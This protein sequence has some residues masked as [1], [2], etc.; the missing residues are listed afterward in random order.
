MVGL[1]NKDLGLEGACREV[2]SY[3]VRSLVAH[4]AS[5]LCHV[6][7]HHQSTHR[8]RVHQQKSESRVVKYEQVQEKH[9]AA[10]AA[11]S[12]ACR[13]EDGPEATDGLDQRPY[14]SS[15]SD[16]RLTHQLVLSSRGSRTYRARAL[17]SARVAAF[18]IRLH[19]LA[20][21]F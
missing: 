5:A 1:K 11:K 12:G 18:D 8:V 15:L 6:P 19:S 16:D 17:L 10:Q 13:D 9:P 4:F 3:V 7:Y 2:R 14:M 20:Q 21:L